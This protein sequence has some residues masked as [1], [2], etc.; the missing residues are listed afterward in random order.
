[1]TPKPQNFRLNATDEKHIKKIMKA[2]GLTTKVSAIRLA[3][4]DCVFNIN[5]K[6]HTDRWEREAVRKEN[7]EEER[8]E[9]LATRE[10][11][12]LDK[13]EQKGAK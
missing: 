9:K 4:T 1:M 13:L 8:L 12:R 6:F 3:L 5:F 2:N 7:A 11:K 10:L